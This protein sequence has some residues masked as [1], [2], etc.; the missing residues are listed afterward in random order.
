MGL[1]KLDEP[2]TTYLPDFQIN[3]R[4]EE[5]PEQKITLRRLLN[6]T[7][8]LPVETPVGNYFEPAS[9][10]SFEDH[11]RS[12]YGSWLVCPVGRSFYYSD[13]SVR[14]GRL[15]VRRRRPASRSRSICKR[16]SLVLWACRTLRRTGRRFSRIPGGRS[17]T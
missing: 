3:S 2:I 6:F 10:A 11:V 8:G 14:S 17:A 9:T 1:V 7:A 15:R 12:L 16:S 4:Y 5:H 13:A